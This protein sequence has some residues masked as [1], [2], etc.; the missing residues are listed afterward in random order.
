MI[1]G[2]GIDIIE[3]SRIRNSFER[4]G[5]KFADKVLLPAEVEY[6]LG[7]RDPAPSLAARF[8]AKEAVSKA[9]G[10]GITEALSW[11]DME[12]IRLESGQPEIVLHGKGVELLKFR[13]ASR[14]HVSLTHSQ[15]FAAA[16]AILES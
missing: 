1:L 11:L 14:V 10:T 5:R 4:F 16:F 7:H 8:A 15:E 3:I 9:F 13:N 2:T 6:C 12:V